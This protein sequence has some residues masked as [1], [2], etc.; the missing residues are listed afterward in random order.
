MYSEEQKLWTK[1]NDKTSEP[2]RNINKSYKF[3]PKG[4]EILQNFQDRFTLEKKLRRARNPILLQKKCEQPDTS[5]TKNSNNG[6]K[7]PLVS[8]ITELLSQ[9]S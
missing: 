2:N 4:F 1:K 3:W 5:D 9:F 6:D 8:D 7:E